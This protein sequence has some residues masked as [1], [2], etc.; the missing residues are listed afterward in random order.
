[1]LRICKDEGISVLVYTQ[2]PLTPLLALLITYRI[3]SVLLLL[4]IIIS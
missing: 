3:N 1:M 2:D 4:Y